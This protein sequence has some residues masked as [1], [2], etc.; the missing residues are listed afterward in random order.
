MF[1]GAE[2]STNGEPSLQGDETCLGKKLE[3]FKKQTFCSG[4]PKNLSFLS[5]TSCATRGHSSGQVTLESSVCAMLFPFTWNPWNYRGCQGFQCY[6]NVCNVT[7][8]IRWWTPIETNPSSYCP[9]NVEAGCNLMGNYMTTLSC[10]KASSSSEK[11]LLVVI[12]N[13]NF[14]R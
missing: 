9:D 12:A 6:P 5:G 8:A 11:G 10:S 14:N 1:Y 3:H 2:N 13:S 7:R 4:K